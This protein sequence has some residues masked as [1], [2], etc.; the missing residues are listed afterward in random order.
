M[1]QIEKFKFNRFL[2]GF[3]KK[4][5]DHTGK[6]TGERQNS[7][8]PNAKLCGSCPLSHIPYTVQLNAKLSYVKALLELIHVNKQVLDKAIIIPSVPNIHYR[9][10]MDFA[11][12]INGNLGLKQKGLWHK[13]IPHHKCILGAESI[14]NAFDI[15]EQAFNKFN[16]KGYD[17][18][19]KKG[20]ISFVVIRG[21][22]QNTVS[23]NYVI[24]KDILNV[25][26]SELLQEYA[27]NLG[28]ATAFMF[29]ANTKLNIAG[30]SIAITSS[31]REESTGQ[32]VLSLINGQDGIKIAYLENPFD[33]GINESINL[34]Y[35]S[36]MKGFNRGFRHKIEM[37]GTED[38]FAYLPIVPVDIHGVT[39]ELLPFSFFQPNLFT[40]GILQQVV[41]FLATYANKKG[42]QMYS[43]LNQNRLHSSRN[44]PVRIL[45]LFGG[46]G[47]L[48]GFI[49]KNLGYTVDVIEVDENAVKQGTLIWK[50]YLENV[51]LITARNSSVNRA[52]NKSLNFVVADA[53][54]AIIPDIYDVIILDPPRRG[55]TK[56]LIKQLLNL[57]KLKRIVYVSCN[58]KQFAMEYYKHLSRLYQVEQIIL[59]DQF[60]H[61]EHIETVLLLEKRRID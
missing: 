44:K 14:N 1:Q 26:N 28:K 34:L 6:S 36:F 15:V 31:T 51:V 30:F 24:R 46:Q 55:L 32:I 33:A 49:A 47:F 29:T 22:L 37:K 59:L 18:L 20:F 19:N 11:V 12:D 56:K 41:A 3:L 10:R 16:V 45:D 50:K 23:I 2:Q 54:D 43:L 7:P 60:P 40:A 4:Y 35:K 61:T 25:F 39:F 21:N 42:N 48:G 53:Y 8:C 13:I 9:N 52:S 58:I 17:R 38:I 57:K 5:L 27:I